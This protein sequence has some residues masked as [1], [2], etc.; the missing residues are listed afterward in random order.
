MSLKAELQRVGI[1]QQE[2]ATR[3]GVGYRTVLRM[4][5]EVSEEVKVLLSGIL[6]SPVSEEVYAEQ[7]VDDKLA[8]EVESLSVV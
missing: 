1:T 2:L 8:E 3:L 4:G 5:D 7:E 6:A